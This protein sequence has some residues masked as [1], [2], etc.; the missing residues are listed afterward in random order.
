M[1]KSIRHFYGGNRGQ[2]LAN[3]YNKLAIKSKSQN[4]EFS[5]KYITLSRL[6][7][8]TSYPQKLLFSNVFL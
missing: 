6:V 7:K 4:I 8:P 2:T 5:G 1:D 3:T